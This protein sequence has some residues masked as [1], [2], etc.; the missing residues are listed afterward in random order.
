M[1]WVALDEAADMVLRGEVANAIAVA[2]ILAASATVMSGR[3][4]REAN[5]PFDIRPT[6]L[7]DRRAAAWGAD[8]DLKRVPRDERSAGGSGSGD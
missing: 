8:A 1:R 3:E 2:G 5:E 6:N 4:R 7:A